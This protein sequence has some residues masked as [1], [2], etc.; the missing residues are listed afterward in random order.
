[1]ILKMGILQISTEVYPEMS[2]MDK[3]IF[4]SRTKFEIFCSQGWSGNM[5]VQLP[6][7]I[8]VLFPYSCVIVV[9]Y[10]FYTPFSGNLIKNPIPTILLYFWN[11]LLGL[12]N[13]SSYFFLIFA[14]F[15]C[16]QHLFSPTP[17]QFGKIQKI[18]IVTAVSYESLHL[19]P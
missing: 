14:I 19:H 7:H 18:E 12:I 8:P 9:C 16:L 5:H 10:K 6:G 11:A 1:M 17:L 13:K 3:N 4:S 2:R 15:L